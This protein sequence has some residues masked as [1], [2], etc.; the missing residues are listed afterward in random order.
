[1]DFTKRVF[2]QS[3][4]ATRPVHV[5]HTHINQLVSQAPASRKLLPVNSQFSEPIEQF[6]PIRV[7][8]QK[9]PI[10]R[11]PVAIPRRSKGPWGC[12]AIL[13]VLPV[14]AVILV[15]FFLPARTNI[16]ILGIDRA[17]EGTDASRTDT[18]IVLSINPLRPIVN[19]LSIPRDLWV[20]I[21]N[22][23]ENRINTAHFFAEVNEPGSGPRASMQTIQENF[24]IPI[25]YYVRIR[26]DGVKE[27]VEAMGGL[28]IELPEAMS[29]YEAGTHLLDG[30]QALAFVRDRSGSD[31]FFRMQRGQLAV[32][33]MIKQSLKPSNWPK[34]P[35][36]AMA[37]MKTMDNNIPVWQMPR[38]GLA[39]ARAA[40]TDSINS[41]TITR[42]MVTPFTTVEGAMV[43]LPNWD[44]INPLLMELFGQ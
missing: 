32:K 14:L 5:E 29:G 42:E 10:K 12:L 24:G 21:P 26:F 2:R 9:P 36:A 27:I 20:N 38:I 33:A 30:D 13:M 34:L 4:D 7:P 11:S 1:M 37:A 31:D 15:Y 22:E 23:G 43:L 44:L 17:P 6:Q 39:V 3:G 35:A 18:N 28:N 41:R 16:L 40:L 19:M 25:D 8:K